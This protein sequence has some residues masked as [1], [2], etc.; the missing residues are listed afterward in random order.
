MAASSDSP[1]E[2]ARLR[3]AN[4]ELSARLAAR[5][6]EVAELTERLES[7]RAELERFAYIASH[8][9]KEP[10]RTVTGFSGLLARRLGDDISPEAAEYLGFVV[11]GARH[12]QA[13]IDG[14][15]AYA[16]AG[17]GEPTTIEMEAVLA[18]ALAPLASALAQTQARIS[19]DP[20]PV[21]WGSL[22]M[23]ALALQ[24]LIDNALK[25]RAE[26]PPEVHL[27]VEESETCWRFAL[28]DN[29]IGIDPKHHPRV[30]EVFQRLHRRD[31][32]PG[33]GVGLAVAKKIIERHGGRIWLES[34]PGK[35]ST[36]FF[37][38]P[39]PHPPAA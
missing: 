31:E 29:G 30:F 16:R 28:A 20:L 8:D 5:E 38:L 9:L 26:A 23:L 36:F 19:H 27:G 35:G 32:Y 2:L 1:D 22:P 39:K 3:T 13:L 7:T 11:D 18:K 37:T 34:Q 14:L 17:G 15:L 33:V 25:F 12:M 24:Q 4:A 21:V 10:L 6:R